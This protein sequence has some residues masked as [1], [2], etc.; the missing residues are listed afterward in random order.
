MVESYQDQGL[1]THTEGPGVGEGVKDTLGHQTLWKGSGK[2][3]YLKDLPVTG[4]FCSLPLTHSDG[5]SSHSR[6][7]HRYGTETHKCGDM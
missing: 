2:G 5:G 7:M 4:G 3:L 6:A 1:G